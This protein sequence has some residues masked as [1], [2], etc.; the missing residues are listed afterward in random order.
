MTLVKLNDCEHQKHPN[1]ELKN[2][3]LPKLSLRINISSFIVPSLCIGPLCHNAFLVHKPFHSYC[4]P[5]AWALGLIMPSSCMMGDESFW[6]GKGWGA[7]GKK[8]FR[9]LHYL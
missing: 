5:H 8:G 4:L 1:H 6:G 7:G 9:E 2:K 3:G